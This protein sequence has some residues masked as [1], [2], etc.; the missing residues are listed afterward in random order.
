MFSLDHI[1]Y[2]RWL[3]VFLE[4]LKTNEQW[5]Q[6]SPG[7]VEYGY[8]TVSETHDLFSRMGVDQAHEKNDK[9]VKERPPSWKG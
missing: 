1:H 6:P 5:T 2:A 9:V 7:S 3:P 4:D 8:V